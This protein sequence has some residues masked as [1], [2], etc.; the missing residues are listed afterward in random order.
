MEKTE[1]EL[2][3]KVDKNMEIKE[4]ESENASPNQESPPSIV[5]TDSANIGQFFTSKSVINRKTEV[6]EENQH[7]I[8]RRIAIFIYKRKGV[9]KEHNIFIGRSC[10]YSSIFE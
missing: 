1:D 5:D 2:C 3:E 6:N 8:S 9:P 10:Y 7:N 4:K